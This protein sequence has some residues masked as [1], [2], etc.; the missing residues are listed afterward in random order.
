[1]GEGKVQDVLEGEDDDQMVEAVVHVD[2]EVA[3]PEVECEEALVA[4]DAAEMVVELVVVAGAAKMVELVVVVAAGAAKMV[5]LVVVVD[6]QTSFQVAVEGGQKGLI[7]VAV[8][9]E[10][11]KGLVVVDLEVEVVGG[12][13]LLLSI[14]LLPIDSLQEIDESL[15]I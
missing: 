10:E 2:L 11:Q 8:S 9:V 14:T 1:M 15:H 6:G 7:V 3:G 12:E 5:E 4:A 13:A